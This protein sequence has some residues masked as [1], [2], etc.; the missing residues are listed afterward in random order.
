MSLIDERA[1]AI[2]AAT[3]AALRALLAGTNDA[4]PAPPDWGA[5][6]IIAHLVDAEGI[7]F[8][9]RIERIIGEERPY[10]RS[11]D[12]PARLADGG[13]LERPLTDL[14]DVLAEMRA[15]HI[16]WLRRLDDVALV[17]TGDHDHA[18]PISAADIVHQWAYHDLQHLRQLA[19]ALQAPLV[20]RMGNTRLFYDV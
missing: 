18:G 6:E 1:L 19:E 11:I 16:P 20:P 5:R 8:V 10:I 4:P 9:E 2:I 12:P 14:L 17:R 7:A 15:A 13:Y 3:P